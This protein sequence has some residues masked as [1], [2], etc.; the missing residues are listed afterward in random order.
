MN[1]PS[2][3]DPSPSPTVVRC[4]SPADFLASLP[5]LLGYVPENSIVLTLFE[6]S[7]AKS[8]ARFDLPRTDVPLESTQL[9]RAMLELLEQHTWVSGAALVVYCSDSFANQPGAPH[10]LLA[11]WL[12]RALE[13]H[14]TPVRELAC[15]ASD[16]WAVYRSPAANNGGRSLTEIA[17]S[18]FVRR[19]GLKGVP[20]PERLRE[21]G[22]LPRPQQKL[23]SALKQALGRHQEMT[24]S[25]L[26]VAHTQAMLQHCHDALSAGLSPGTAQETASFV[27]ACAELETWLTPVLLIAAGGVGE[28]FTVDDTLA[29]TFLEFIHNDAKT[30]R[31]MVTKRLKLFSSERL[32]PSQLR[33]TVHTLTVVA[34]H[35]PD[36]LRPGVLALAAWAWW[37]GGMTTP[38]V[39]LLREAAAIDANHASVIIVRE[40]CESGPPL[41]AFTD[42]TR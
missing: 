11:M 19:K 27:H 3:P 24:P 16:G 5:V 28:S 25:T 42:E 35:T 17:H 21:L 40:L 29:Q 1:P 2:R 38:A 31:P 23:A 14:G 20:A 7:Q 10:A 30:T 36:A 37:M 22:S 12:E 18:R 41:W 8:A 9:D 39:T 6:G 33:A 15:I 32:E 34:A 13:M 4:N 26:T